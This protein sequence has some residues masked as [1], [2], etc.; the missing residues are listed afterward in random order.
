MNRALFALALI[1]QTSSLIA[2]NS[3]TVAADLDKMD[4]LHLT[5][6]LLDRYSG[7]WIMPAGKGHIL[8]GEPGSADLDKTFVEL[9]GSF[10]PGVASYGVTTWLYDLKQNRLYSPE[11]MAPERLSFHLENNYLPIA[12]SGWRAGSL[13]VMKRIGVVSEQ[14]VPVDYCEVVIKNDGTESADSWLYLVVRSLGP[15][16]GRIDSISSGQDSRMIFLNGTATMQLDPAPASLGVTAF[17]SNGDEISVWARRGDLPAANKTAD[18]LGLASGA[19]RYRVHLAPG[20]TFSLWLR[21]AVS[22][23]LQSKSLRGGFNRTQAQQALSQLAEEWRTTLDKVKLFSADPF[24][25]NMFSASVAY[26]LMSSVGNQLRVATVNYPVSYLRDGVFMLDAIEKAGLQDR[27]RQYLDYFLEHPW[28]GAESQQ[29]PEADAPGELCWII[30]EH[31]RFTKDLDWLRSVYPIIKRE[32]DLIIFMR[33]PHD[34]DT[35]EVAGVKLTAKG[36]LVYA[37]LD[38]RMNTLPLHFEVELSEAR[39]GVI[40]GRLDWH[41]YAGTSSVFAIAGLRTAWHAAE[42]LGDTANA[43]RFKAEYF[44]FRE[45]INAWMKTHPDEFQFNSGVWPT[46]AFDPALPHIGDIGQYDSYAQVAAND[47]HELEVYSPNG[48]YFYTLFGAAHSLL[49]LGYTEA[50]YRNLL[51]PFLRSPFSRSTLDAYGYVE[52]S[53][54]DQAWEARHWPELWADVRGWTALGTCMP[55]GWTAADIALLIRDLLYYESGQNLVLAGGKFLDE[56]QVGQTIGV[57]NGVT[58][59]GPLTY[60]LRRASPTEFHLTLGGQAAPPAGFLLDTNN[61]L[62]ICS[63]TIDGRRFAGQWSRS[64]PVPLGSKDV[65]IDIEAAAADLV[66]VAISGG[67]RVTDITR[68][69]ATLRWTTNEP[70]FTKVVY[71]KDKPYANNVITDYVLSTEHTVILRGLSAG[72]EYH[73]KVFYADSE[74]SPEATFTT[75]R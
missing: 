36:N 39:E 6:Y 41:L 42:A 54:Q 58:Y 26:I 32:A 68:D 29:G 34:G 62:K 5:A 74:S 27:A 16:G 69:S 52:Y 57:Q 47:Y 33:N 30:G 49:R 12:N 59:F 20:Q 71:G 11:E 60:Q 70:A 4:G 67:P 53:P 45:A 19:A 7:Q 50:M 2:A 65:L 51:V 31:Y 14:G 23:K 48:H 63:V 61:R 38:S 9:D 24:G 72:T 35:R 44:S 3:P 17:G 22:N 10:S 43:E 56:M 37:T 64:I 13:T 21:C 25:Q 75:T 15:A 18:R 55:H 40:V 28:S 46:D 66:H 73:W 8:L 1:L